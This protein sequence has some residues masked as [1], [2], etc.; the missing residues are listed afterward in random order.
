MGRAQQATMPVI[1]FL[2]TRAADEDPQLLA[3][4]LQGLK[5]A[6]YVEGRNVAIEYR[7][8]DNRYDRL[9]A[10]AADLV[11]RGVIAITANGPAARAAKAATST[12]PI[13][14]TAGF[15]PVEM[16]LVASLSRPGGN[17]TGITV[18]DVQLGAKRLDLLHELVPGATTIAGLVNPGDPARSEATSR[19]L[20]AAARKLGLQLLLVR[21]STEN[22]LAPVFANL[23][24]RRTGGLV[25]GGD[26]FFNSKSG[27]LGALAL[28]HALPAVF[29]FRLFAAAGGL[30]SY[31]ASLVA[32]YH[33]AGGYVGR[34]LAG[35]NPANLPVLQPTTFELVINLKT[36]KALGLTIPPILLARADDVI[37]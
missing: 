20:Q 7:Y 29:Q 13:V 16:G 10:L 12:I 3:A 8:A 35:A 2:G 26:P 6:G 30:A 17:V 18:L 15:D 27:Q 37:E 31:G 5:D 25:I 33:Q 1:G 14:F 36:A 4:F 23:V 22:E 19:D 11:Q 24:E 9:P 21:A 28:R 32:M 34:I